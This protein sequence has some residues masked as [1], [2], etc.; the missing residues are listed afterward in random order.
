MDFLEDSK[1]IIC[2]VLN[3]KCSLASSFKMF[4]KTNVRDKKDNEYINKICSVFFKKYF[5]YDYLTQEILGK[6]TNALIA[7]LGV[8]IIACKYLKLNVNEVYEFLKRALSKNRAI[9]SLIDEKIL[10]V[11]DLSKENKEYKLHTEDTL[12]KISALFNL[13]LWFIKMIISQNGADKSKQIFESFKTKKQ[14]QY[15]LNSLV[16]IESLDSDELNKF[17]L[18]DNGN[19]I[20]NGTNSV[21]LKNGVIL[22]TY[23]FFKEIIS[24]L[25]RYNNKYVT[26]YSSESNNLFMEFINFVNNRNNV[27]NIFVDSYLSAPKIAQSVVLK[28]KDNLFIYEGTEGQVITKLSDKQDLIVYQPKS[29]NM[30]GFYELLENRVIFDTKNLDEI[31]ENEKNGLSEMA[32]HSDKGSFLCYIV[33]TINKHETEEVID[34]FLKDHNDFKLFKSIEFIASKDRKQFGYCAILKRLSND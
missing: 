9:D 23:D 2:D 26:Y 12:L 8:S 18:L 25:G 28:H 24:N 1:N 31:I 27:I 30:M 6:K 34:E 22:E 17:K 11:L 3:S 19:Y 14:T 15:I 21:L 29:S 4:Q 20:L 33:T 10:K 13:P 32:T 16:D 7:Y 5:Y